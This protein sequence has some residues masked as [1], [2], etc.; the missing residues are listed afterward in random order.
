MLISV[1]LGKCYWR[2]GERR[3]RKNNQIFKKLEQNNNI[4]EEHSCKDTEMV[5]LRGESWAGAS[6]GFGGSVVVAGAGVG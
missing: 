2:K 3:K 6:G 1:N 5:E 4:N